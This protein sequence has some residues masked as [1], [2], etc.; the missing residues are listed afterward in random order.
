MGEESISKTWVRPPF[1]IAGARTVVA[2]LWE[3]NDEFSRGLMREFYTRLAAGMD[4]GR[5]FWRGK[6]L[7]MIRKY[8]QDASSPRLWAGFI[9]VG[10]SRRSLLSD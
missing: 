5:A 8:G 3:S 2:N 10:E 4:K 7:E 9:M 1:L 6:K